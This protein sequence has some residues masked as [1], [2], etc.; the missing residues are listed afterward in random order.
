MTETWRC[1]NPCV[2][3]SNAEETNSTLR[4]MRGKPCPG[5]GGRAGRGPLG[6]LDCGEET[7]DGDFRLKGFT[8]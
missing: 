6:G 1:S 4:L 7:V 3:I 5:A 8:R 2:D